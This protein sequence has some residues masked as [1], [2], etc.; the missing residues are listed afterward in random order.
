MKTIKI[1]YLIFFKIILTTS[2]LTSVIYFSKTD[3]YLL[4]YSINGQ[5]LEK[6]QEESQITSILLMKWNIGLEFIVKI[7]YTIK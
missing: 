3:N 5:L 6:S 1:K 2:P 7:N 4:S